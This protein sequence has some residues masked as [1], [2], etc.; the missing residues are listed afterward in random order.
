MPYSLEWYVPGR[1]MLERAFGDVTVE[2]LVQLNAEVT[3]I[4]ASEGIAPVHAILDLTDIG[5]YPTSIRDILGTMRQTVPGKEGWILVVTQSAMLNFFASIIFQV[6]RLRVR[7]FPTL[8]EAVAYLGV[9][10]ETFAHC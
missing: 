1:V 10:D 3:T 4:I 8:P 5:K 7:V 2:E 9:V 6:A